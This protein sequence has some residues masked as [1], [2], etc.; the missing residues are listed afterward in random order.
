MVW[1]QHLS[2]RFQRMYWFNDATGETCWHAPKILEPKKKK[3]KTVASHYDNIVKNTPAALSPNI[4]KSRKLH[5]KIKFSIFQKYFHRNNSIVDLACGKGGDLFKLTQWCSSYVGVDVS[6]AS[7]E[8]ARRRWDCQKRKKK[9]R[10]VNVQFVC[11][12]LQA[13]HAFHRFETNSVDGAC[14]MFALHYFWARARTA[15]H[16][17]CNVARM[18]KKKAYFCVVLPCAH[19]ITHALQRADGVVS[20]FCSVSTN[21]L[22][23]NTHLCP[24]GNAYTFLFKG[25]VHNL[26]EYLVPFYSLE[27]MAQAAGMSVVYAANFLHHCKT[28]AIA[29]DSCIKPVAALYD[30][31]V[32]RM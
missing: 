8:E 13:E 25:S 26:E 5:N 15:K 2:T 12:N 7:I 23:D 21:G 30:V 4:I 3:A 17:F 1:K 20:S 11:A 9:Y 31:V 18:L 10:K 16:V 27:T 14:M 29:V 24:W 28:H 32:F 19:A 6:H 22:A